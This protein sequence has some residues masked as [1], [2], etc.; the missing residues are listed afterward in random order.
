MPAANE[1]RKKHC[2]QNS[3]GSA[4]PAAACTGPVL[5]RSLWQLCLGQQAS[6]PPDNFAA[7]EQDAAAAVAEFNLRFPIQSPMHRFDQPIRRRADFFA[8]L[9]LLTGAAAR[10]P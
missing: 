4:P 2:C 10:P 7:A 1:T 9:P 8:A 3:R 5:P 6:S